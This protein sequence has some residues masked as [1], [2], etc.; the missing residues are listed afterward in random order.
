MRI[1][2]IESHKMYLCTS[3]TVN[4]ASL[5]KVEVRAWEKK[6]RQETNEKSAE[7]LMLTAK[8]IEEEYLKALPK[9]GM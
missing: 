9:H 6:L 5:H 1:N 7:K 4:T 3:K 2:E 8:G